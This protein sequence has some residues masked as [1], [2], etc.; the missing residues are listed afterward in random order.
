M[1]RLSAAR[2]PPCGGVLAFD[3]RWW[4]KFA[5]S[6]GRA[7][8][9]PGPR[10]VVLSGAVDRLDLLERD[11]R[12]DRHAR[13][14]RLCQLTGHLA[15]IA[16]ALLKSLQQRAAAGQGDAAIHDVTRKLRG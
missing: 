12:A 15:L 16:Q 4:P 1:S 3:T 2:A 7:G 5:G 9:V 11:A 14:R 13:Q 6:H 10:S 8:L